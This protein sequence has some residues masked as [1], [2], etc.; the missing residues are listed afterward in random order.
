MAQLK[1]SYEM[2]KAFPGMIA[3]MSF[4]D[5]VGDLAASEDIGFGLGVK[6]NA[7]NENQCD[8][9][10]TDTDTFYGVAVHEH[11]PAG[12]YEQYD[13]VNIM[14]KGRIYVP[15]GVTIVIDTLAYVDVATAKFTNVSAGNVATGGYFRSSRVY[16]AGAT[17]NLAVLEINKP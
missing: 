17:Y 4:H 6:R 11:V 1:Y 15:V 8:L 9:I 3:D 12:K 14:R 7:S 5:I 13:P 2:E 10:D 16:D